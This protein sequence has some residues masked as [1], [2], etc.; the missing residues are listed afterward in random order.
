MDSKTRD[1]STG[2][3]DVISAKGSHSKRQKRGVGIFLS[4]VTKI[5]NFPFLILVV[6]CLLS[7]LSR[8]WLLL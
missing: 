8:V 3:G 2:Q 1:L 5:E 7:L 6:L 4:E